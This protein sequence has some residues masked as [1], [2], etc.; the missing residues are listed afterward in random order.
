MLAGNALTAVFSSTA[1]GGTLVVASLPKQLLLH[2][3]VGFAACL[4]AGGATY[5]ILRGLDALLPGGI[6]VSAAVEE[7]GLDWGIHK[8]RAYT[9]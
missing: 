1:L 9:A 7:A 3:A 2:V 8:E 5:A 4:W 6:R